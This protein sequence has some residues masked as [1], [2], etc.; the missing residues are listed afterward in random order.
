M[1]VRVCAKGEGGTPIRGKGGLAMGWG[2]LEKSKS[3]F[4]SKSGSSGRVLRKTMHQ[5]LATA[6]HNVLYIVQNPA[7]LHIY[8]PFNRFTRYTDEHDA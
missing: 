4:S 1:C 5:I 6:R 3:T 8:L 7:I 2:T